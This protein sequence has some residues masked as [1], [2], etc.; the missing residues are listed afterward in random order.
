MD[1][2][3]VEYP[4]PASGLVFSLIGTFVGCRTGRCSQTCIRNS[5]DWKT[6]HRTNHGS[7]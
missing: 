3:I 4:I 5:R 6:D 2:S 1:H 7:T